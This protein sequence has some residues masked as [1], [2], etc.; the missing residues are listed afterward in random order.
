[1]IKV[2]DLNIPV[3]EDFDINGR[4]VLLRIDINSPVDR[5]TG[6]LLDDSRIKAHAETI[7]EL[8]DKQNSVVI[9][10]HQGRPGDDDFISLEE[11]SKILSKYV[12]REIEFVDDVIGPYA[13]EKISKL[14]KGEAILLENVRIVSEELIEAPPQQQSKTFLVRKLAPLVDFYINDAFATAHRSQPSLVGFPLVKPSAAGRIME[15]EVSALSKIFNKEDSPKIFVLGG[16]KVS[17]TLKIIE[18]LAKNRVADRILTGGLVAELFAVA[19]GINLGKPN[20][21]VLEN[22]GLL[23][24]I[25]RARKILLSGAP[26][27]IP[28]DFTVE[29]PSG[30]LSNDPE[31][32]VSGII[33]DIGNT[34]IE[35]YSSFIKEGKVITLRGPMGV[36]EDERFRIGTKSLLKASIESPGYVIIG[37]GHMISMLDKDVEINPNKIHVSTGGGALLLFLAGDKLPALEALHMSWVMQSGKS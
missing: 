37:G 8:L 6:K 27:E 15:K 23:S 29:K 5:K 25:P 17:D 16:S 26:I 36:I 18:H 12:G 28:V 3:I 33:K 21:Q 14:G 9:I 1:M 2:A 30:E 13:R 4:K 32:N 11:H 24:L 34:T 31:N 20:M 35:I 10:S 22:K 7:R 19:K